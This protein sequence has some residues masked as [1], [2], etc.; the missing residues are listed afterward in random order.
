MM[1]KV[2]LKNYRQRVNKEGT[3][4]DVGRENQ[5]LQRALKAVKWYERKSDFPRC[6]G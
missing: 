2:R 1:F 4:Y 5:K 6:F 3:A